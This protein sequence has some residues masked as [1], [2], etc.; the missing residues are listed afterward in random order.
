MSKGSLNKKNHVKYVSN[1]M[2]RCMNPLTWDGALIASLS[3][4]S[5]IKRSVD[6]KV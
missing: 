2:Y 4:G 3:H 1:I 6:N 5:K